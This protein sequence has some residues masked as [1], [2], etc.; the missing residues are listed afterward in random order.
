M[1]SYSLRAEQ[2]ATAANKYVGDEPVSV[3]APVDAQL[4][5]AFAVLTLAEEVR[6][7]RESIQ[8]AGVDETTCPGGCR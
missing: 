7:L 3:S 2:H 5:T 6:K 4:A 1:A 8:P